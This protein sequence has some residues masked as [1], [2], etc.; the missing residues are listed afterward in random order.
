MGN[1]SSSSGGGG[2]SG[3]GGSGGS[4]WGSTPG[5]RVAEHC[6]NSS[7]WA[8]TPSESYSSG[9]S[10][11]TNG[12]QGQSIAD[13]NAVNR[14]AVGADIA[15]KMYEKSGSYSNF[16]NSNPMDSS[17]VPAA[18]DNAVER[19][20]VMAAGCIQGV[21]NPGAVQSVQDNYLNK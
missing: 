3:S 2:S 8:Q 7:G 10:S 6:G 19:G 11:N 15:N 16:T 18:V 20:A 12:G 5:D 1:E 14:C 4:Q 17:S 21:V 13:M 9:Y